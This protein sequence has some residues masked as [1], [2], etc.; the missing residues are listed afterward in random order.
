VIF[1]IRLSKFSR[2]RLPVRPCAASLP[3]LAYSGPH[4]SSPTRPVPPR[5]AAAARACSAVGAAGPLCRRSPPRLCRCCRPGMSAAAAARVQRSPGPARPPA[6][7]PISPECRSMLLATAGRRGGH[8]AAAH[9]CSGTG[10]QRCRIRDAAGPLRQ[11]TPPRRCRGPDEL[12]ATETWVHRAA[13]PRPTRL[14]TAP[15]A[16]GAAKP[17]SGRARLGPA[18]PACPQCSPSSPSVGRATPENPAGR[19]GRPGGL[20][21]GPRVSRMRAVG[22]GPGRLA[23]RD[24]CRPAGP[25]WRSRPAIHQVLSHRVTVN[26]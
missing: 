11:R 14:K 8:A 10:L 24:S 9:C 2:L 26:S 18:R 7:L 21:E 6:V 20:A 13:G 3:Q 22:I 17:R 23:G 1:N 19:T 15:S 12:A 25:G 16:R 4:P 5:I